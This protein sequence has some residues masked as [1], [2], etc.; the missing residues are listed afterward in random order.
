MSIIQELMDY[1]AWSPNLNVIWNIHAKSIDDTSQQLTE[2]GHYSSWTSIW[3][4]VRL[5]SIADF[6]KCEPILFKAKEKMK[7]DFHHHKKAWQHISYSPKTQH[8]LILWAKTKIRDNAKTEP[9][10]EETI[11]EPQLQ[12]TDVGPSHQKK[13]VGCGSWNLITLRSFLY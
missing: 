2:E 6:D 5:P 12:N 1:Q 3:R 10:V 11:S 7:T 9:P 13:E 8:G 4:R